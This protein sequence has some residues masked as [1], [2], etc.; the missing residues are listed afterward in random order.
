VPTAVAP[1]K[2]AEPISEAPVVEP[3]WPTPLTLQGIFYSKTRPFALINGKTV[4]PGQS[5]SNVVVTKIEPTRVTVEWNG[6]S[7]SLSLDGQ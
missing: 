5:I 7:K 3:A 2:P 6:N 1:E 4:E